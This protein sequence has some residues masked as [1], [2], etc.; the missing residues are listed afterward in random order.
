MAKQR[1]RELLEAA[2]KHGGVM[3]SVPFDG[4]ELR[5]FLR[6][7]KRFDVDSRQKRVWAK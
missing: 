6:A 4:T 3:V 7:L 5:A 1:K 2:R